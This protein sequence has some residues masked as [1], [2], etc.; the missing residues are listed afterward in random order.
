MNK[1]YGYVCNICGYDT[2]M[3]NYMVG[4]DYLNQKKGCGCCSGE[5]TVIGIND[6]GTKARWI[7]PYLKNKDDTKL[8]WRT[9]KKV[10]MI[11]PNCHTEKK[12]SPWK[13]IYQGFGC[14]GCSDGVSYGEK[15]VSKLLEQAKLQYIWQLNRSSRIDGTKKF[16]WCG[17]YKYDFY[18]PSCNTII[19][20]NGR[21]HYEENIKF[22][23]NYEK[24]H[25][26]DVLKREL[27]LQNP[28]FVEDYIVIDC[29]ESSVDYIIESIKKT[30]LAALLNL[31]CIDSL[32]LDKYASG[33]LVI[34]VSSEWEK[35]YP[36]IS[37]KTLAAEL[38]LSRG[39]ITR[40]LKKG[41]AL[42]ICS[43]QGIKTGAKERR[44]KLSCPV[45]VIDLNENKKY[46]FQNM[47]TLKQQYRNV[48]GKGYKDSYVYKVL[49]GQKNTYHNQVFIKIC[50]EE[51]NRAYD[52]GEKIYGDKFVL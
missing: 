13:M 35:R 19:E 49:K 34:H 52:K 20:V 28:E 8:Y 32:A 33:S 44:N 38:G 4:E 45:C 25:C 26:N 27:A 23:E 37:T 46:Y 7:I 16:G 50:K 14:N 17:N 15:I 40:Y 30:K 43:Y 12:Q 31:E 1:Y 29:R 6:I 22:Y 18:L 3:D 11:C 2:R 47:K 9:Q 48:F 5:R 41:N 21:Q 39:A 36:Q 42:G 10:D 24:I 51:F